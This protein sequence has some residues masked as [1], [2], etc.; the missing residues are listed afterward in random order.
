M[1][2][3]YFGASSIEPDEPVPAR[4]GNHTDNA[5]VTPLVRYGNQ[6]DFGRQV[7]GRARSDAARQP[8]IDRDLHRSE[9]GRYRESVER[10]PSPHRLIYTPSALRSV[11]PDLLWV[12]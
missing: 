10:A 12:G 6:P 9:S 5:P 8:D 4:F 11:V 2:R 7:P 1:V 3:S